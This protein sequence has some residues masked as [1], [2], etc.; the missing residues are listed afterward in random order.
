M[1]LSLRASHF[2]DLPCSYLYWPDN[3]ELLRTVICYI[4]HSC[5]ETKRFLAFPEI[6]L[7]PDRF[8][9]CSPR[10]LVLV[11]V[12]VRVRV[13]ASLT[14]KFDLDSRSLSRTRYLLLHQTSKKQCRASCHINLAQSTG[15]LLLWYHPR[16]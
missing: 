13:S 11:C 5:R 4:S 12:H 15:N 14:S 9:Q 3:F 7:T 6:V 1:A 10:V 2:H 8:Y 16:I